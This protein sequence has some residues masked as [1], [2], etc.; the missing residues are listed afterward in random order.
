MGPSPS[1]SSSLR[2]TS[3]PRRSRPVSVAITGGIGAG[4]SELL[5]AFERQG[6]A[7]V[8]SD[9]IVHTLLRQDPEVKRAVVERFGEE[10]LAPDGEIDRGAVARI[11]FSSRRQL[12]WLEELLHPLV[13]ATYLRWREQLAELDEPPDVCIT[14]V[15]LLYEVGG[16]SRFDKV[17]A[18]TA[19]PDVRA[20]RRV[21]A[22]DRRGTR[23]IPDDEK[24]R[25]ADFSYVNDGS[26]ED[27]DSFAADVMA[28]LTR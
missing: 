16:E 22:T 11:V 14:E 7:V 6:A 1:R 18:V 12:K 20:S 28:R 13:L 2:T 17:V 27:L 5:H 15:P 26:R 8:S 9:E 4:K 3:R 21:L 24:L 23:L 19:S 25:R 10:I